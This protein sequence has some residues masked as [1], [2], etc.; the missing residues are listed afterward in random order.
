[1]KTIALLLLALWLTACAPASPAEPQAIGPLPNDDGALLRDAQAY[2]DE[3]GVTLEEAV[4]RL[5]Q[6]SREAIGALQNQLQLH[7]AETFAG[8]WLQHQPEYRLVVAFTHNGEQTIR[9][10]VA[11]E[12]DLFSLLEVRS[13]QYSLAQLEA[14][15]RTVIQIL[16]KSGQLAGGLLSD[17]Q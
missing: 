11:E 6:Q 13:A 16:D 3:M 12:S 2:A 10:Y 4:F 8:L 14:D 5:E 1:M 17:Q 9:R 15:Q 7:E